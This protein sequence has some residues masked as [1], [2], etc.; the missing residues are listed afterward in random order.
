ML[1]YLHPVV[2]ACVSEIAVFSEEKLWNI[3]LDPEMRK[4]FIAQGL[5]QGKTMFQWFSCA[6]LQLLGILICDICIS[7]YTV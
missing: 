6:S 1:L 4:D 7:E 5:D 3:E 2:R